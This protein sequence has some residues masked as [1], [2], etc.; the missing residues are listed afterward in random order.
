MANEGADLAN[1]DTDDDD[2]RDH[3]KWGCAPVM[4]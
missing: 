4:P 2:V 1:T 3:E